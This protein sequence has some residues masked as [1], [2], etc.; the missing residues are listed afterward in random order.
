M[1]SEKIVKRNFLTTPSDKIFI[2][3]MPTMNII[4]IENFMRH[5]KTAE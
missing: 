5:D 3:P 4:L 2:V 1:I